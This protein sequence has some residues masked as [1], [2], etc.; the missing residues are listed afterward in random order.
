MINSTPSG[1]IIDGIK[2]TEFICL[3]IYIEDTIR[4][5]SPNFRGTKTDICSDDNLPCEPVDRRMSKS[6][7]SPREARK[8][9][10]LSW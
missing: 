4:E 5:S 3:H 10:V 9:G 8:R 1:A 7:F 6:L 2:N